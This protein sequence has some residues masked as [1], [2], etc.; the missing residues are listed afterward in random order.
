[1]FVDA[2]DWIDLETCEIAYNTAITY[3]V[4]IVLWSYIK[5]YISKSIPKK[6]DLREGYYDKLETQDYLQR[7]MVGLIGKEL[8]HPE[9][10]SAISPVW[11]KLFRSSIIIKSNAEFISTKTVGSSEDAL[12]NLIAFNESKNAYLLNK[13]YYHYRKDNNNSFTSKYKKE[14][15]MRWQELFKIMHRY[16]EANKLTPSYALALNNRIALSIIGLGI[17]EL[18]KDNSKSESEKINFIKYVITQP[19]YYEA[20]KKLP[21][22][23]FSFHWRVFFLFCKIRFAFGVYI[24][25][26]GLTMLR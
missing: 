14:S 5:E 22:R 20:Y 2:D 1:M 10:A 24:L 17:N 16:I 3:D 26:K 4:D 18:S 21:L 23:Y 13:C 15:Y 19:K 8:K 6:I 25:L 12:F 11:G 9:N 7:R